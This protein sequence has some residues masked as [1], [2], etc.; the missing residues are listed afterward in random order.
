M[1][2][3]VALLMLLG[4]LAILVLSADG[5]VLGAAQIARRMGLSAF[6]VGVTVVAFGTS[7]PELFASIGAALQGVPDLAIGNVTGSNIANIALILGSGAI[8]APMVIAPKVRRAEIPLMVL[9]TAATAAMLLD[10]HLGRAEG[11]VLIIALAAY[12][13]Y[14]VKAHKEEILDEADHVAGPTHL[15]P[16]WVDL[17]FVV[18]GTIGLA[19][20]AKLLV[21]GATNLATG[22]GVPEG[23]VGTTIVAFGTSVP[24]LATTV[25]AAMKKTTDMALGNVV[26]S[27]V[28]NL[29]SV[30]GVTSTITPLTMHE[31]MVWH[32]WVMTGIALLLMLYAIARPRIDRAVGVLLI[33]GYLAYI[34]VSYIPRPGA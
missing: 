11:I 10:A 34:A 1:S 22:V 6:A 3:I 19:L 31:Q 18:G 8:I 32:L 17:L 24:E 25:R 5:L 23:I 14:V 20:G 9:I 2:P 7:A 26:G 4:G 12:V 15:K 13:L 33:V 30:L 27:N 28:F 16:V 21:D 29:L